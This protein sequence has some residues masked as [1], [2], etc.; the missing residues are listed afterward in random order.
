MKAQKLGIRNSNKRFSIAMSYVNE[1]QAGSICRKL[2]NNLELQ[3][4]LFSDKKLNI[5][6]TGTYQAKAQE[7]EECDWLLTFA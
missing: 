1:K 6:N 4:R 5:I 7:K 2:L 3:D